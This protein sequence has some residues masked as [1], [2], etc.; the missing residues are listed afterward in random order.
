MIK[1]SDFFKN[2]MAVLAALSSVVTLVSFSSCNV[3]PLVGILVVSSIYAVMMSLKKTKINLVFKNLTAVTV[4]Q[5]DLFQ[6][7]GIIVIPVNDFFDTH[8]GDGV[9]SRNSVHGQFVTKVFKD[10]TIDLRGRIA[11]ALET[12][13]PVE[14]V[15]RRIN[16]TNTKR[17]PLGTCV[18][19][20]DGGKTYVLFALT[21]FD[22]HDTA[23]VAPSEIH[24][25]ISKLMTHLLNTAEDNPVYIPVFGTKLSRLGKSPQRMLL[26]TLET[27]DFL[28]TPSLPGGLNVI[29]Y[30]GDM[31]HYNLN[32]IETYFKNG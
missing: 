9:I 30:K 8:V 20:Y 4:E 22:E 13:R 11:R 29:C 6:H 27:I 25:I 32:M 7:E 16:G 17:Y 21:T 26:Y 3:I 19:I 1:G 14:E 15:T 2:L 23:S 31:T 5:G 10:R 28:E 12:E 24:G 18:N